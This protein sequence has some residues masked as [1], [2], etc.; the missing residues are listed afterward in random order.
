MRKENSR[1]LLLCKEQE[2]TL[3]DMGV[4][5]SESTLK[6][7]DLREASKGFVEAQWTDDK[8][9]KQCTQ[10]SKEFNIR[11]RK[12]GKLKPVFAVIPD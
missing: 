5:L 4:R 6:M 3:E 7:E 2:N 12:V 8:E 9:V 1:L 11:R 10:C